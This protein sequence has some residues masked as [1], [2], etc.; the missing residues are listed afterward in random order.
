[1]TIRIPDH[2]VRPTRI[3]DVGFHPN[4]VRKTPGTVSRRT[5]VATAKDAFVAVSIAAAAKVVAG[6][7]DD[8]P[9]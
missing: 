4:S 1:M 6:H 3:L 8:V 9:P 5:R 7:E 2:R